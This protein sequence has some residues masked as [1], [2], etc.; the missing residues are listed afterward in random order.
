MV[1]FRLGRTPFSTRFHLQIGFR[2]PTTALNPA[3]EDPRCTGGDLPCGGEAEARP[4]SQRLGRPRSPRLGQ[5]GVGWQDV[6][7]ARSASRSSCGDSP[8]VFQGPSLSSSPPTPTPGHR[9]PPPPHPPGRG[10]LPRRAPPPPLLAA[11]HLPSSP[12]QPHFRGPARKRAG[13]GAPGLAAGKTFA[14]RGRDGRGWV[15]PRVPLP[16]DRR[17]GGGLDT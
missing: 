15:L 10:S 8:V 5:L 12:R 2:T 6:L 1:Q 13:A 14:R 9:V 17:V 3:L 16:A 11:P 4:C 7:R